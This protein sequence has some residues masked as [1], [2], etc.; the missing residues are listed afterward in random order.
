[1][2]SEDEIK[3]KIKKLENELKHIEDLHHDIVKCHHDTIIDVILGHPYDINKSFFDK[4]EFSS[5][6]IRRLCIRS[7]LDA[8]RS[9]LAP[10]EEEINEI[11]NRLM[12]TERILDI[13]SYKEF[14]MNRKEK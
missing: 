9:V 10:S 14:K 3:E 5:L 4:G 12:E 7:A 6:L 13:A 2:L 1:M 11:C 8:L